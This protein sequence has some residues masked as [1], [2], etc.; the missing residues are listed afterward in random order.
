M[1]FNFSVLEQLIGFSEDAFLHLSPA[2]AQL[3]AST[4]A[5]MQQLILAY[6]QKNKKAVEHIMHK[7]RGSYATLGAI[8]L[9]ELSRPLEQV[10]HQQR[11]LPSAADFALYMD[12][13][14]QSCAALKL[15]MSQFEQTTDSSLP[16]VQLYIQYLEHSDMQ[17]Y[18]LFQQQRAGWIHYLGPDDFVLMEQ[19]MMTLD[20]V[21]A[22]QRLKHKINHKEP[23]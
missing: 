3:I 2:V 11:Q 20:F 19:D 6:Q 10:L 16:D 14:E 18:S 12:C 4:P 22:A 23:G 21:A 7:L 1:L 9:P 5:E 17:A 13:L 8:D 15:W